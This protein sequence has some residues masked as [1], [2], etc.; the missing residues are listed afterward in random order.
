MW[1]P[2]PCR[3]DRN[4]NCVKIYPSQRVRVNTIFD[5]GLVL[6]R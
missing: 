1:A 3:K 2:C 6:H 4:G 5:V